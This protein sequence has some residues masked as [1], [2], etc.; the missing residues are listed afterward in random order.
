MSLSL[1]ENQLRRWAYTPISMIRRGPLNRAFL[2]AQSKKNLRVGQGKGKAK[3]R[4]SI[5]GVP[6][7]TK[8]EIRSGRA[9]P[10]S[11]TR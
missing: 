3:E 10:H 8:R 2:T 11:A 4:S 9:N 5:G 6:A 7:S 1:G